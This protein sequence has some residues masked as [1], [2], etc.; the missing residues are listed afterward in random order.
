MLSL[1]GG[2]LDL[3]SGSSMLQAASGA[4]MM[5]ESSQVLGGIGLFGLGAAVIFTGLILITGRFS[6]KMGILGALMEVYGI[7]M[8]LASTYAPG[9]NPAVEDG[10]LVVGVLMFLN[11]ILMQSRRKTAE[12]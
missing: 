9:M 4:P 5:N 6:L 1:V 11:G 7:I 3:Y 2:V 12:M 8:G 10:M